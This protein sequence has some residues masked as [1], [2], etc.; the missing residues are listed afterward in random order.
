[1]FAS[2]WDMHIDMSLCWK[3]V[4]QEFDMIWLIDIDE[5]CLSFD[6]MS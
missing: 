5:Q 6:K 4:L 1:V 2:D 3:F